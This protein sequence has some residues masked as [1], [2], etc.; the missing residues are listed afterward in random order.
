MNPRLLLPIAA[1][2]A[3]NAAPSGA[4][5]AATTTAAATASPAPA[6]GAEGPIADLAAM[7]TRR[8]VPLQPMMAW[9]QKQN[10]MEHLVA[11]QRITAAL[12]KEDWAA[13]A[14][15][16]ALIESSPHMQQMCQHMGMGAPGF[17]DLALDFHRRADAI[18]AAAANHDATQVLEAT[19]TTLE[20][21][22][23]CHALYR[24]DVVDAATWEARAGAPLPEDAHHPPHARPKDPGF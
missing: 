1:L 8:P 11:I 3:C 13:V 6:P 10:M 18:G 16:S 2:V 24:Q 22:T 4:P 7:D 12:A 20:A 23:T 17:T 14:E 21:C 15:A 9:H 5:P 19:A